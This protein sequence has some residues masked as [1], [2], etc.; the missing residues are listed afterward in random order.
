MA[1]SVTVA[2][3]IVVGAKH[4]KKNL[5]P[6]TVNS[7]GDEW[8]RFDQLAMS[9]AETKEIF[10]DYFA[11]FPWD[12]LPKDASGFDMGCGTGRWAR[13]MA[14]M[15]GHLHCI[16]PSSALEV[17]KRTLADHANVTFHRASV[18]DEPLPENSQDFGYSLGVLHHVPDTAAAMHSCVAMLK[19]GAPFLVYLYYA[20]DNRATAYKLVWKCSDLVRRVICRLNPRLKQ[21]ATD[22][23]AACVY[24]PLARL[25][26]L[27]ERIGFNVANLPLSYYRTH[28][29]Y[30]MRTDSRD[31]FGTPLEGRFTR[32]EISSMM[33][34][35]GLGDISFSE[36]EPYWCAVG[37]KQ[38]SRSRI[39]PSAVR[40]IARSE[41][42]EMRLS[43]LSRYDA[44]GASSRL[45]MMRYV[46]FLRAAGFEV[47]LRPLLDDRYVHALYDRSVSKL[48]VASRYVRRLGELRSAFR[49]DVVWVEKELF[50]WLPAIFERALLPRSAAL[51]L[52]FDDAVFHRYDA[53]R[54]AAVRVLLGRKID[55]LMRRADLVT[56]G[57]EYLAERARTAGCR[58][59][60]WLPT[61][62][63]LERYPSPFPRMAGDVVTIGWIG[64]PAT[65]DYLRAVVPV[66]ERLGQ[67]HRLRCLAI[68]ARADQVAGTPFEPVA[69]SE[70]TE[71]EQ[72]RKFDI[73]IMP[74]PD[75]PWERGKCGY[76]LIQYMA[77]GLPMVASP[78]GANRAIV[79]DGGNGFLAD[80]DAQWFDALERL[81]VDAG[82]RTRIGAEGRRTVET[83]YNV[84]TQAPRLVRMLQ[85]LGNGSDRAD[86]LQRR[87][88][89]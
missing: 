68:G 30:V 64:S 73:G 14:P 10:D 75:A 11:I 89:P 83:T 12:M 28:S 46:P 77:C 85:A 55:A 51:V 74:L 16:D 87:I 40:F 50:P 6:A 17:A 38:G 5:D 86:G 58:R 26:Q 60:E 76:K 67:R 52:D 24:Y 23:L 65:A 47:E 48:H 20:F 57:N 22:A 72:L 70:D 63:D 21:L 27:L 36:R 18:D 62:I 71:V 19:P 34:S 81:I 49:A 41:P 44:L 88:R 82:L 39:L 59:V 2:R 25:S 69:W 42:A 8:S 9:D 15:I 79:A 61:V 3:A 53:H 78:V 7:H 4:L 45:R 37:I 32:S 35:A 29:F 43:I 31:R 80:T 1:Y 56:A 84:Q 54:S 66:L 33:E 13:L